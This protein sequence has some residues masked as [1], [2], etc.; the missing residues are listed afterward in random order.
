MTKNEERVQRAMSVLHGRD[1]Q[2]VR[3]AFETTNKGKD[4]ETTVITYT[5]VKPTVNETVDL[6]LTEAFGQQTALMQWRH[7]GNP[8][9][10][11]EETPGDFLERITGSGPD[12]RAF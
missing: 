12:P 2:T 3:D 5:L 9:A 1:H 4:S 7:F 6:I 11:L 10:E 8:V